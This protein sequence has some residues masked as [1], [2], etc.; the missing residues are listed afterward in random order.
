[1]GE[2]GRAVEIACVSV[3]N[4][5]VDHGVDASVFILLCGARV[6]AI[7]TVSYDCCD[8]AFLVDNLFRLGFSS[9]WIDVSSVNKN[10]CYSV[11]VDV[12]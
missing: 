7:C 11:A 1:M 2:L 5:L 6:I 4:E 3:L 12:D 8:S 9:S 10:S